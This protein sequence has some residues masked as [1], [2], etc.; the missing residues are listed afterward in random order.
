MKFVHLFGHW[1]IS[2]SRTAG[3]ITR[4]SFLTVKIFE[5]YLEWGWGRERR[6]MSTDAVILTGKLGCKSTSNTF[7][8]LSGELY[9]IYH[10][11][12]ILIFHR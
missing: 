7:V 1:G 8:I 10:L 11:M 2:I 9:V 4:D 12:S 6:G 3:I 5:G